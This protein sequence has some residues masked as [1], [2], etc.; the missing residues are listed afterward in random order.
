[1]GPY[2]GEDQQLPEP[3][4]L[5]LPDAMEL[6]DKEGKITLRRRGIRIRRRCQILRMMWK[7][8]MTRGMREGGGRE[9]TEVDTTEKA[10]DEEKL[11]EA[12]KK[13]PEEEMEQKQNSADKKEEEQGARA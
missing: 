9:K 7:I 1:M 10:E 13:D 11:E 4:A 5:D 8:S 2:H 3:E 12:V 6:D